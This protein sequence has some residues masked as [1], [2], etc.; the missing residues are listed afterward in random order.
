VL[1]WR[2]DGAEYTE[3]APRFRRSAA[4]VEQVERLARYKLAQPGRAGS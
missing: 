3:I 2:D 4:F 1:R